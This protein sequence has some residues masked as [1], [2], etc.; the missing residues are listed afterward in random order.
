MTTEELNFIKA[1]EIEQ[2]Y[3]S[4]NKVDADN[5]NLKEKLEELGYT[6]ETL[7]E[8]KKKQFMLKKEFEVVETTPEHCV[9]VSIQETIQ[10]NKEVFFYAYNTKTLVFA[11]VD[12]YNQEYCNNNNIV[13][14]PLDYAGGT[15]VSLDTDVNLGIVI[16]QN[17][18]A[19]KI[20]TETKFIIT[21]TIK[22]LIINS[23][24]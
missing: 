16:K 21:L 10:N 5:Y 17:E 12:D 24:F 8:E 20:L 23:K 3:L 11:G 4:L 7:N 18:Y 19:Y 2:T 13:V 15:I 1:K 6:F 22:C 14:L 9:N